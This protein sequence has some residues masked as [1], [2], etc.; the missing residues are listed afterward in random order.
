M[1]TVEFSRSNGRNQLTLRKF[2]YVHKSEK[3]S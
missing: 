2:L 1:D 3:G